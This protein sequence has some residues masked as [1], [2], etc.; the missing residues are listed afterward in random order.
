MTQD[1]TPAAPPVPLVPL[2]EALLDA[3]MLGQLCFD[4][5]QAAELVAI[6]DRG[7]RG[8]AP[9]PRPATRDGL[10]RVR[11]ELVAGT[12][13]AVQL[14]YRFAGEE[15]WDTVTRVP[16]GFRLLRISHTRALAA[17]EPSFQGEGS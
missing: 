3:A 1:P 11:A 12:L 14:R 8:A 16:A 6:L 4:L 9:T 17:R 7:A 2:Q 5:G 13:A 15:W 10:E